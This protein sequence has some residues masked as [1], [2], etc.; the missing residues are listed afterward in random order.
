MC[1]SSRIIIG[2]LIFTICK[3]FVFK[4]VILILISVLPST[5]LSD[6]IIVRMLQHDDAVCVFVSCVCVFVCVL[7]VCMCVY[8]CVCIIESEENRVWN[9]KNFQTL[10]LFKHDPSRI[11]YNTYEYVYLI[12]VLFSIAWWLIWNTVSRLCISA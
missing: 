5:L 7:C 1:D 4:C 8:S 9:E 6:V 2:L 12:Y 10:Q 11:H 3:F